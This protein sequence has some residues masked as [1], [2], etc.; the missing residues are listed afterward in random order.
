MM[1]RSPEMCDLDRGIVGPPGDVWALG[2]MIYTL[3][4]QRAPTPPIRTTWNDI[5]WRGSSVDVART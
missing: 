4:Y 5:D 3:G 2:C 1:N